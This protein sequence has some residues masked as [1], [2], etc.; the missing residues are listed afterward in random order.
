[1]CDW[2]QSAINDLM[3]LHAQAGKSV[4]RLKGGDPFVFGRGSEEVRALEEFGISVEVVPGVTSAVGVPACA[5]IPLTE[6]NVS[7][8]F[9]VVTGHEAPGKTEAAV[10]W[11][12]L[13]SAVDTIVVLMGLKTL[14]EIVSRLL[15]HGRSPETAVAIISRGSTDRQEVV[16]GTL[17]NIVGRAECLAS[18]ATIVI[19]EVVRSRCP[20]FT[21]DDWASEPWVGDAYESRLSS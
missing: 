2:S 12:R 19:G 6:R 10:H 7:S 3:I 15:A 21:T 9:A 1:V 13:A 5:G 4:V 20:L 16:F 14:P 8:S 18:P 11:G 17:A